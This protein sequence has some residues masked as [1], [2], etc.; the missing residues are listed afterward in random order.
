MQ[1]LLTILDL[2]YV[3]P[4]VL[5]SAVAMDK[6]VAKRLAEDVGIKVARWV[7]IH[8]RDRDAIDTQAIIKKLSL[9]VFVKPSRSGSSVGITKVK[10]AEELLPAID[11]AFEFDRKVLIEELI[12]GRELECS[13]LGNDR[14]KASQ[15]GEI[16]LNA[17][18]YS[19]DAK[20]V[21]DQ[22]AVLQYPAELP[23]DIIQKV[24]ET[25]VKAFQAIECEGMARVDYRLRDDGEL[26][27]NEINTIPGFTNISMYPKMWEVSGLNYAELIDELIQLAIE[28]HRS[29]KSLKTSYTD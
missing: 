25:S 7:T 14:P 3:G 13:V 12:P 2:P 23:A 22:A 21:D 29:E 11:H 19:Y 24:Q 4:N 15:P 17:E 26:Y 1:G 20:Y 8:D 9:P 16:I 28:R 18:F 27:L 10:T 5:G 6:E